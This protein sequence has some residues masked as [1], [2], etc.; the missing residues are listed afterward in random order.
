MFST[1]ANVRPFLVPGEGLSAPRHEMRDCEKGRILRPR[2]RAEPVTDIG[3]LLAE[4]KT[5]TN[6][7]FSQKARDLLENDRESQ[8]S[9]QDSDVVHMRHLIEDG[10]AATAENRSEPSNVQS[11][12]LPRPDCRGEQSTANVRIDQPSQSGS[13]QIDLNLHPRKKLRRVDSN[14]DK[15]RSA[16]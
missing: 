10:F 13:T 5:V 8:T 1:P 2:F 16:S 6:R 11:Q 3:H 15:G 4:I 7:Y 9:F 12:D 14:Q